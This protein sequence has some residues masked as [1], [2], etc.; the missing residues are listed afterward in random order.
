MK[1]PGPVVRWRNLQPFLGVS[2]APLTALIVAAILAGFA[3]AAVLALVVETASVMQTGHSAS[4]HFGP[5]HFAGVTA[6][7]LISVAFAAG[8]IRLLLQFVGVVLPARLAANVQANLRARVFRRFVSASWGVQAQEREGHLQEIITNQVNQAT[9]LILTVATGLGAFFSFA[10]LIASAFLLN[11]TAAT[12]VIAAAI[13]L[14][15]ALRPF[16]RW[17]RTASQRVSQANLGFA[18]GLTESVRLA[19]EAQVF[20]VQ[21][22]QSEAMEDLI[23]EVRAPF[24]RRLVIGNSVPP[25]YQGVTIL[26][27]VAALALLNAI[28]ATGLA[29]LGAVVLILLRAM[30]YSQTVQGTYQSVNDVLPF[31]ERVETTLRHYEQAAVVDGTL[32][33]ERVLRIGFEGVSFSYV[34]GRP[35]LRDIDLVLARGEAIGIV[36]P[37]GA[38]KSTFV[39]LL[40]RLRLPGQGR[41]LVNGKPAEAYRRADWFRR[42]AYLPQDTRLVDG[43]VADNI[44]FY[45]PWISDTDIERAARLAG[46]HGDITGW[47]EGYLTPVGQRADAVSGGQRQRLC[48]ARALAGRPDVLVLDEPTSALDVP[49]ENLLQRSLEELRGEMTLFIVAHRLSTLNICDRLLVFEDGRISAVGSHADLSAME[50]FYQNAVILTHSGPTETVA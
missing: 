48:L 15:F 39:Q 35:V 37:S 23:E 24:F 11:V 7:T 44:R 27:L 18:H 36:G 21:Q 2:T 20:G 43:T 50:G 40:L 6:P 29:S 10:A 47:S 38:G 41:M 26:L 14:F 42:V 17:N 46:I 33:L 32:T 45:R 3:E 19:E 16:A 5:V 34:P 49:S 25:I 30:N 13:L 1:L 22:A 8:I 4:L 12:L 9:S 28:G 31:V